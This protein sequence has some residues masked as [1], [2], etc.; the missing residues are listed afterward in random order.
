MAKVGLTEEGE[1]EARPCCV[2]S[3]SQYASDQLQ[4]RML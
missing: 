2:Q 1:E 4:V 3:S